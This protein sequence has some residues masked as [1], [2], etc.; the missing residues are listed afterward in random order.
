MSGYTPD[1]LSGALAAG[2][3][4]G[5]IGHRQRSAVL[6]YTT[7][8]AA[9]VHTVA[10]A[11]ELAAAAAAKQAADA[12]REANER[13]RYDR[14]TA[15]PSHSAGEYEV[16]LTSFENVVAGQHV[17]G[18]GVEPDTTVKSVVSYGT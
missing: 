12:L 2:D 13:G 9:S 7:A 16:R 15:G 17:Q 14:T 10:T 8:A 5:A 6:P 1:D 11:V 18:K 4:P 3:K